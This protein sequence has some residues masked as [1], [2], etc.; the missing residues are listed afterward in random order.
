MLFNNYLDSYLI[1][2]DRFLSGDFYN[3]LASC[4]LFLTGC[5]SERNGLCNARCFLKV[6]KVL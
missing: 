4:Y 2:I 6:E 3:Y 1:Y 5:R